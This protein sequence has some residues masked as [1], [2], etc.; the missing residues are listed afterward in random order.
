M[1]KIHL[2]WIIN[3]CSLTPTMGTNVC[4]NVTPGPSYFLTF[5]A[6]IVKSSG[7]ESASHK[8]RCTTPKAPSPSS[9]INLMFV[10]LMWRIAGKRK[11]RYLSLNYFA[12]FWIILKYDWFNKDLVAIFGTNVA[13][14]SRFWALWPEITTNMT[15]YGHDFNPNSS[16]T[17]HILK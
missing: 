3:T 14:Y 9:R 16:I 10:W 2:L 4:A 1:A 8:P 13:S 11:H 7:V 17:S 15:H 6:T 5:I 12:T